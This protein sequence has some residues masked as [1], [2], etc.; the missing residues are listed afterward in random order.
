MWNV[1]SLPPYLP[2]MHQT[3]TLIPCVCFSWIL[4]EGLIGSKLN[5]FSVGVEHL[6]SHGHTW[7]V[8]CDWLTAEDLNKNT[9]DVR[10]EGEGDTL[11]RSSSQIN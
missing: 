3:L 6:Y 7:A 2:P 8:R 9:Q 11:G 1:S 4:A 10:R 5:Y